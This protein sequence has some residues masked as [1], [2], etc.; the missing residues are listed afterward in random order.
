MITAIIV[1]DVSSE[2]LH[3]KKIL[4]ENFNDFY[5]A[6]LCGTSAEATE[7]LQ[8]YKPQL[9]LF[10]IE[11]DAGKLSFDILNDYKNDTAEVVFITAYNHYALQAIQFSCCDYVLKPYSNSILIEAIEK[12]KN[13][14]DEKDK[15]NRIE[16][17]LQNLKLTA[18]SKKIIALQNAAQ[19]KRYE[20]ISVNNILYIASQKDHTSLITAQT[21]TADRKIFYSVLSKGI[22]EIAAQFSDNSTFIRV[23][24]QYIINSNFIT[25]YDKKDGFII[26]YDDKEI[27][28]ARE[29]KQAVLRLLSLK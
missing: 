13:R 5:V 21:N 19:S 28:I 9:L 2:R 12:A 4:E 20:V 23:H 6:A 11:L 10:D 29:R 24:S 25:A 3:L 18:P 22:G 26:M 8:K 7:A 17:L 16:L 15:F 14:I 27:P 1:E